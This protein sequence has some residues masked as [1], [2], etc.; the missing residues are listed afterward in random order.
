MVRKLKLPIL[1]LSLIIFP[2]VAATPLILQGPGK[3]LEF[4]ATKSGL[5][6]SES[7]PNSYADKT[8]QS[9]TKVK[10]QELLNKKADQ[11]LSPGV[12]LCDALQGKVW[13]LE[14]EKKLEW[15][16]CQ[17]DDGSALLTDDL[18]KLSQTLN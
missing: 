10:L 15:S 14:D 11:R 2:S 12:R 1:L 17:F 18:G 6:I 8:L 9:L 3:K 5:F 16:I 4:K 13:V 7:K